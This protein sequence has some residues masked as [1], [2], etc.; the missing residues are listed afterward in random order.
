MSAKSYETGCRTRGLRPPRVLRRGAA[1]DQRA[2]R[3]GPYR[4]HRT[5][6]AS[7]VPETAEAGI[8]I[9]FPEEYAKFLAVAPHMVLQDLKEFL[10]YSCF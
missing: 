7:L 5:R 3:H 1:R 4:I 10:R 9:G 6:P 2:E 8:L